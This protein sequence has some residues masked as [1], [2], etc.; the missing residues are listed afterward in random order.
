MLHNPQG[1]LRLNEHEI[2]FDFHTWIITGG[3]GQI[4]S[5][6]QKKGKRVVSYIKRILSFK[7]SK[8]TG[9]KSI[10]GSVVLGLVKYLRVQQ[11]PRPE[12]G[13]LRF[14]PGAVSGSPLLWQQPPSV[15]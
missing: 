3:I 13:E 10:R 15:R 2:V 11:T 4:P 14:A 1:T 7:E 6:T 12:H 8:T 9:G 5:N